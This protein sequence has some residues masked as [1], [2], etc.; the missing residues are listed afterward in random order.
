M[1][2]AVCFCCQCLMTSSKISS[3]NCLPAHRCACPPVRR[4]PTT[5]AAAILS[6]CAVWG[7]LR[8]IQGCI[9][10]ASFLTPGV[11]RGCRTS[12]ACVTSARPAVRRG[13]LSAVVQ[14]ALVVAPSVRGQLLRKDGL[15]PGCCCCQ[16]VFNPEYSECYNVAPVLASTAPTRAT[17][18]AGSAT[19]PWPSWSG[20]TQ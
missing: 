13:L 12:A 2:C 14:T 16:V 15:L 3:P 20:H 17:E 6:C 11:L 5:S 19:W 1:L 4:E 10:R 18:G 9:L 8:G 7:A